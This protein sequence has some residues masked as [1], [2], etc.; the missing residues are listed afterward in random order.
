MSP[1]FEPV[2]P[3]EAGTQAPGWALDPG[4]RRGDEADDLGHSRGH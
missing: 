3:A 2:V 4:F 1:S